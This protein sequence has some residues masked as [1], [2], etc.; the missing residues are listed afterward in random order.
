MSAC[1]DPAT[2]VSGA[3]LALYIQLTR[4]EKT[5]H[6]PRDFLNKLFATTVSKSQSLHSE[7]IVKILSALLHAG[8]CSSMKARDRAV[9]NGS[10]ALLTKA[11]LE[12]LVPFNPESSIHSIRSLL[13]TGDPNDIYL[14][15]SCILCVDPILWAG[16]SN[17]VPGTLDSWEVERI[18]QLLE[19][20]D[21][22][23]RKMTLRLLNRVD[24]TIVSSYYSQALQR[25][26]A[27]LSIEGLNVSALRMIDA[28]EA[29]SDDDGEHYARGLKELLLRLEQASQLCAR[30]IL[31]SVVDTIL[32]HLRHAKFDFTAGFSTTMLTFV[33]EANEQLSQTAM[34]IIAAL[35]TE[36]CGK[37][38]VSSLD[39][40]K[41][42]ASKLTSCIRETSVQ[43]VSLLAMLR[44]AA[45][46]DE[47]P[48]AIVDTVTNV[49]QHS[50]KHIRQLPDFLIALETPNTQPAHSSTSMSSQFLA[51]SKLRYDA[52]DTPIQVPKLRNRDVS[53]SPQLGG[54]TQWESLS[55][56][57]PGS[58]NRVSSSLSASSATYALANNLT[59]GELALVAS[60]ERLDLTKTDI[61]KKDTSE[62]H[63]A[64]DLV[65]PFYVCIWRAGSEG[66]QASRVDLITLDS[67]FVAEPIDTGGEVGD[68]EAVWNS[69]ENGDA[70]GWFNGTVQAVIERM[71]TLEQTRL[72]VVP[73]D[74]APYA[75]AGP[76]VT[77][78][79]VGL[80]NYR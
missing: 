52:Y 59:P 4:D 48:P 73:K 31:E 60:R 67:P 29:Q 20:P 36:Q 75:G 53:R 34:T 22:L 55:D 77:C 17:Q 16:T 57:S 27:D 33:V 9:M 24:A 44:V 61:S 49:G 54:Q 68:F 28:L 6:V 13:T 11:S 25:I 2:E 76:Y 46:C 38:S 70:R 58:L 39:V 5:I 71:Q 45:E 63:A 37:L 7:I 35:T 62:L 41:G 64:D 3:S 21:S 65:C 40:L 1:N 10:F 14:F 18:M 69:L 15:L 74:S 23:I 56:A 51:A 12:H 43:D 50:R 19:S 42:F 66:V 80:M 26:P 30:N 32:T 79:D 47:V 8:S 72:H 78:Q